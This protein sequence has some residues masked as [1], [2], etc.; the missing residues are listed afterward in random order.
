L[1]STH[2]KKKKKKK[3]PDRGEESQAISLSLLLKLIKIKRNLMS[4]YVG[5]TDKKKHER[6]LSTCQGSDV[7]G[8]YIASLLI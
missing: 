7:D 3:V 2:L 1:K 8:G 6:N 4:Q 5:D